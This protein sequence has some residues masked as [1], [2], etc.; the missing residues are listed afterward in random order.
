MFP[1]AL[2]RLPA[3]RRRLKSL[4]SSCPLLFLPLGSGSS[5]RGELTQS[6]IPYGWYQR[7]TA[8]LGLRPRSANRY[9]TLPYQ[10]AGGGRAPKSLT[11][12]RGPVA[13]LTLVSL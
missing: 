1:E 11:P 7:G 2:L 3:M 6:S 12:L 5:Q 13:R 10:R 4:W 8:S 9:C